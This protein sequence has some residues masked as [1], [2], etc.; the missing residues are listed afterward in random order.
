[1]KTITIHT[2][3]AARGN[4]GPAAIAYRIDYDGEV[5]EHA[6]TIGSTTNNQAE[7][8]AMMA[9]CKRLETLAPAGARVTLFSD[10]ELMIRQLQ[11]QYRVK[12]ANLR[13]HFEAIRQYLERLEQRGNAIT[14]SAVRRADALANQALDAG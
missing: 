3:G 2:D 4:P 13:P 14:L 12:D 1:L 9:A 10:S 5:L 8:Q 6:E 11:G 7:Y